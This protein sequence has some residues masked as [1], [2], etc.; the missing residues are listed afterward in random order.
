MSLHPADPDV[1]SLL[2]S[3]IR[4]A[5]EA[6]GRGDLRLAL[7]WLD[8]AV[9]LV[10]DNPHTLF[11]RAVLLLSLA[12]PEALAAFEG[13]AA[14]Y[15]V[16]EIWE[17]MSTAAI[18][19]GKVAQARDA[20]E[21]LLSRH[22]YRARWAP[23]VTHAARLA[24]APGWCGLTGG[25]GPAPWRLVHDGDPRGLVMRLDGRL[26]AMDALASALRTGDAMQLDA[27]R[28]GAALLGSPL[29]IAYIRRMDGFIER[30]GDGIRGWAWHP[31]DP[32]RDPVIQI[33][34]GNQP[35]RRLHLRRRAASGMLAPLTR[36]RAIAV[37]AAELPRRFGPV[38]VG[39]GAGHELPGS[40]QGSAR[41]A[42]PLPPSGA[43]PA[44]APARILRLDEGS[45]NETPIGLRAVALAAAI[46]A[47][48]GHDL[49]VVMPGAQLSEGALPRLRAAAYADGK[50]G[51]SAPLLMP[52]AGFI[53]V[54]NAAAEPAATVLAAPGRALPVL[55]LRHDCLAAVPLRTHWFGADAALIDW[56]RRAAAAGW[57][58]AVTPDALAVARAGAGVAVEAG[59][60]A[61]MRRDRA[62]LDKRYGG[63]PEAAAIARLRRDRLAATWRDDEGTGSVLLITHDRGGGVE[64]LIQLRTA[65]LRD[66]GHRVILLRP[67]GD[68]LGCVLSDDRS[69]AELGLRYRLPSEWRELV[70]FLATQRPLRIELHHRLG[71][72]PE[73]SSLADRLGVPLDV[74]VHDYA[75]FCP[76]IDLVGVQR[77]YCGEPMDIAVCTACIA[78]LGNDLGKG[79]DVA[80]LRARSAR[81]FAAAEQV[82]VPT[83]DVA[84]RLLR[85]FP[86]VPRLRD[87]LLRRP[88][89][90][91]RPPTGRPSPAMSGQVAEKRRRR[92][93]VIGAIGIAKG[94]DVL[95]A[96]AEDAA[97]RDLDLEFRLVGFSTGD[98]ALL[99]TGRVWVTGPY[100][101]AEAVSLIQAQRADVALLPSVWPETWCFALS[102]AWQAG[103]NVAMFDFGGP[104]ERV[105]DDRS[106]DQGLA[107][108]S[109][110]LLLP[111]GLPIS[112]IN[113]R[114]I[115]FST[116]G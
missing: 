33:A 55:Y 41:H 10:P 32:D 1:A 2:K 23:F 30:T 51:S 94:F 50:I 68:P 74:W 110:D 116:L 99:A 84:R 20:A 9:R 67:A 58:H 47:A 97:A 49:L 15:D 45:A 28:D 37:A 107:T 82:V 102:S 4:A 104:A 78:Q 16:A 19:A 112:E 52:A 72:H 39:D 21:H 114:L 5:A 8:R 100:R 12:D 25:A 59:T 17:G 73:I 89:D 7:D 60:A 64:R 113:K 11:D 43:L 63:V 56:S 29:Q 61:A 38:A 93:C 53:A 65:Q 3:A 40:R 90:S 95:L 69:G 44:P 80:A 36:P 48:P 79:N 106:K 71:H 86:A 35:A 85:H 87:R 14:R 101:E 26:L 98:A 88:W 115:L 77:R 6:R 103:L 108:R 96:C 105:R 62:S 92:V 91:A 54:T 46:A 57:R 34:A 13:L 70:A 22:A 109:S 31:S 83:Q 66:A 81:E 111:I 76:R 75:A 24:G 18:R 42:R 27:N